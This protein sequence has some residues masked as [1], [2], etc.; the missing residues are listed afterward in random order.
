MRVSL[1]AIPSLI[2][3]RKLE[4]KVLA[5]M[6]DSEIDCSDIP[7]LEESFWLTVKPTS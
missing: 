1:H 5:E 6:P 4:L 2:E 3:E 7:P